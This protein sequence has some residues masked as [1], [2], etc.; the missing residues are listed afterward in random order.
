MSI[1]SEEVRPIDMAGVYATFAND[2]VHHK[3]FL[4]D[5]ILDRGGTLVF[6][7]GDKGTQVMSPAK[8]HEELVALRAVVTGG[9]GVAAGLADRQAAGKTGT[10]ERNDN[11]WFDGVTPQLTA[12]VWMGS[13]IGNIPMYSV[14]GVTGS[15]NYE[16]ARTVFGGTYPAMIWHEFMTKALAGQPAIDFPAADPNDLG[17]IYNISDPPGSSSPVAPTTTTPGGATSTT[18]GTGGPTT[19]VPGTFPPGATTIPSGTFP[20]TTVGN[21]FPPQTTSPPSSTPQTT[22]RTSPPTTTPRRRAGS[23]P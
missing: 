4:V 1:G 15:G 20:P 10:A 7:G 3:P 19:S 12:V 5:H 11:A 18:L 8:A 13:P 16:Y 9:T 23:S 22:P 14:G 2:G 6:Q 21:T 17:T